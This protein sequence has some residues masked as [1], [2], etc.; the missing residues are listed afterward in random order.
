[1]GLTGPMRRG[2]AAGLIALAGLLAACSSSGSTGRAPAS[3]SPSAT[4][5]PVAA[6]G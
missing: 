5:A 2:R 3:S 6:W 4:G 1:M